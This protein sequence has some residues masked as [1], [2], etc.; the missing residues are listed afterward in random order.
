[1]F[2]G[3]GSVAVAS[4]VWFSVTTFVCNIP[5]CTFLLFIAVMA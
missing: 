2:D 4:A 1:M 3:L 5:H